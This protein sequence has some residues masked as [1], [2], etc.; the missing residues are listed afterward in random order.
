MAL[1]EYIKDVE[2]G[3]YG[4]EKSETLALSRGDDDI[5]SEKI[6]SNFLAMLPALLDILEDQE[7]KKK[8]ELIYPG[9]DDP[10]RRRQPEQR[11]QEE[12]GG[13]MT[14]LQAYELYEKYKGSPSSSPT[15]TGSVP[16]AQTQS[17][18]PYGSYSSGYP[19]TYG[20]AYPVQGMAGGQATYSAAYP[21]AMATGTAPTTTY[22]TMAA[23][24]T[25]ATGAGA[26]GAGATGA[27]ATGAGAAGAGGA[28]AGG[29]GMW[30][31]AGSAGPVGLFIL[32]GS[33]AQKQKD[34]EEMS[35]DPGRGPGSRKARIMGAMAPSATEA[36][37][38]PK[39]EGLYQA[40]GISPVMSLLGKGKK[41]KGETE[42][43][44]T[45]VW[46]WLGNL[47]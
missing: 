41:S 28:G 15:T 3:V 12:D 23:G 29:G 7:R 19:T 34:R 25:T 10:Y 21:Q 37:A 20:G 11:R 13:G 33:L 2:K 1:A 39:G 9:E 43:E 40:L 30:A 44:G 45:K 27:G 6:D 24:S 5:P 47:F 26:T 17:Y 8:D 36:L 42:T 22:G 14:P 35:K 16:V 38:D 46:D 4:K 18:S 31:S 32:L